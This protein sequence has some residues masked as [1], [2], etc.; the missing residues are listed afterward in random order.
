[1]RCQTFSFSFFPC[2]ADHERDWPPCKVVFFGLATNALNVRNVTLSELRGTSKKLITR[3]ARVR[4]IYA[5]T[6]HILR[7]RSELQTAIFSSPKW[8]TYCTVCSGVITSQI[9]SS[10]AEFVSS[11]PDKMKIFI[12]ASARKE[13]KRE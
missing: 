12:L 11:I 1:M 10:S 7:T 9:T 4:M 5:S 6:P 8:G 2:S 3:M 13:W